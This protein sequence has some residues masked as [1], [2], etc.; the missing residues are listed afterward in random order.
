M[1]E[2]TE[3]N[4]SNT[5]LHTYNS[6]YIPCL[7]YRPGYY[8]TKPLLNAFVRK[9]EYQTLHLRK[10]WN[11]SKLMNFAARPIVPVFHS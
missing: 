1:G 9:T 2:V 4:N 6:V 3:Y 11:L 5:Q 8:I 7:Q 10:S